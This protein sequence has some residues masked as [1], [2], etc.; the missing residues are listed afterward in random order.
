MPQANRS[1]GILCYSFK[2][3]NFYKVPL[4]KH[5]CSLWCRKA[6]I[7][8]ARPPPQRISPD[9]ADSRSR[10]GIESQA[11]AREIW[12]ECVSHRRTN[13]KSDTATRGDTR[14]AFDRLFKRSVP[15]IKTRLLVCELC[16]PSSVGIKCV[17]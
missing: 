9:Q 13:G 17:G 5:H 10:G 14:G 12:R 8:S 6:P 7:E 11:R 16:L 1:V 3:G 2:N 4:T 15:V